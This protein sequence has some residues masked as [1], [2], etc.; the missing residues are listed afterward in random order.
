MSKVIYLSEDALKTTT[1]LTEN[2]QAVQNIEQINPTR[3]EPR[4]IPT[5]IPTQSAMKVD[6]EKMAE[7]QLVTSTMP[8][9]SKY[10]MLTTIGG[11]SNKPESASLSNPDSDSDSNYYSSDDDGSS[12]QYG[13]EGSDSASVSSIATDDL[14]KVDPLY[15]RL[16]KF[17]Q[18]GGMNVAEILGGIHLELVKMNERLDK[19]PPS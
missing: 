6:V 8:D 19:L 17:L 18:S 15:F 11:E 7:E 1:N 9:S 4:L 10:N 12:S 3:P 14:L 13:G 16:T 2:L 5:P